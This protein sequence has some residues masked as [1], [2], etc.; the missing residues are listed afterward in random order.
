M[1]DRHFATALTAKHHGKTIAPQIARRDIGGFTV[2]FPFIRLLAREQHD[3]NPQ[4]VPTVVIESVEL[5][6]LPN[7]P[8]WQEKVYRAHLDSGENVDLFQNLW[9]VPI[10]PESLVGLTPEEAR[11]RR[12]EK[13][14]SAVRGN[15]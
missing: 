2:N 11:K 13:V 15:H 10:S 1:T 6:A 8:T 7:A 9:D 4:E 5:V 12:T 14:L 3:Q